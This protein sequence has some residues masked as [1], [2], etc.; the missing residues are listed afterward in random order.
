M[1]TQ[2]SCSFTYLKCDTTVT[3]DNTGMINTIGNPTGEV[4]YMILTFKPIYMFFT[5]C[6]I[7]KI[8]NGTVITNEGPLRE[9][10]QHTQPHSPTA[11]QPHNPASPAP[12]SATLHPSASTSS[13]PLSPLHLT[14]RH[15]PT[16]PDTTNIDTMLRLYDTCPR[17]AV[18]NGQ[19]PLKEQNAEFFC[20]VL[21][22]EVGG[23]VV[24][25]YYRP[26]IEVVRPFSSSVRCL[27]M[28]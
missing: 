10:P 3:G 5:T 27:S 28:R 4:N 23:L 7:E 8:V 26:I 6:P 2:E 17:T 19:A 14:I 1:P 25:S 21:E 18:E 15:S 12:A 20:S 9:G 11:P 16:P 13:S 22:Y 24:A